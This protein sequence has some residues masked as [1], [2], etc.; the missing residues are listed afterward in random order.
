MSEVAE[1]ALPSRATVATVSNQTDHC[2]RG[3]A[4]WSLEL[5]MK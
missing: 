2:G 4:R 3:S 1:F 5:L